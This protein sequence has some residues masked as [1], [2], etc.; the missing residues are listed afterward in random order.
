MATR[1]ERFKADEQRQHQ[2]PAK[3]KVKK[4]FPGETMTKDGP[5]K[6]RGVG[7]TGTRNASGHGERA[8][9]F[10]LEDS[11]TKPSRK[12]TRKSS[13]HSKFDSNLRRRAERADHKPET[14]ASKA[15]VP[16]EK[17]SPKRVTSKKAA[18]T[19]RRG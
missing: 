8:A 9:T 4:K 16:V 18:T 1:A 2:H 17:P 6:K 5:A 13:N 11:A 7:N 15:N 14:R 10:A 12:S 19:K 3:S